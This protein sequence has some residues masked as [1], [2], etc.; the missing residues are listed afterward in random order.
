MEDQYPCGICG[1]HYLSKELAERCHAWC[2]LHD[3]CNLEVARQSVEA[4]LRA[5]R[6]HPGTK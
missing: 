1:L 4:K 3:S 6:V 2:A 5:K